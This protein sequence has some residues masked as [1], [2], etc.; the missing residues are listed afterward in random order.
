MFDSINQIFDFIIFMIAQIAQIFTNTILVFV[1]I[2]VIS[3]WVVKI[4]KRFLH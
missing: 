2:I 3:S 1:L 4:F